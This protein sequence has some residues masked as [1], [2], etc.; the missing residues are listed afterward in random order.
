MESLEHMLNSP[1]PKIK[2]VTFQYEYI[3]IRISRIFITDSY[4]NGILQLKSSN[5]VDTAILALE[6][7]KFF[8]LLIQVL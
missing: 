4:F 7:I 2:F 6:L 5:V 8:L 1:F 3:N